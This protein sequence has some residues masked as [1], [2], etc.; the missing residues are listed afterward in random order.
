MQRRQPQYQRPLGTP[1]E[2][3][4]EDVKAALALVFPAKD[5]SYDQNHPGRA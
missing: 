3:L 2:P 1:S 4:W 5:Q